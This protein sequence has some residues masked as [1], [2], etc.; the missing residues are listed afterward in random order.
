M[1]CRYDTWY[2]IRS[3][4]QY[5]YRNVFS[6]QLPMASDLKSGMANK[7]SL[8]SSYCSSVNFSMADSSFG[9]SS[10]TYFNWSKRPASE[11]TYTGLSPAA[12][13]A[14]FETNP[15][16]TNAIMCVAIGGVWTKMSRV[17]LADLLKSIFVHSRSAFLI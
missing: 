2:I 6:P 17:S 3:V 14:V 10:E 8:G 16:T 5:S 12:A 13:S 7:S 9:A 11:N 15:L 4:A 1:K